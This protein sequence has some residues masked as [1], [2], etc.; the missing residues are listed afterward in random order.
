M[1][2]RQSTDRHEQ[3][4]MAE[5]Q[6]LRCEIEQLRQTTQDLEIALSTIA[7]HGDLV[8]NHLHTA[9]QQLQA[10]IAQRQQA[11]AMLQALIEVLSREKKDLEIIVKTIMEHGDVVDTQWQHKLHEMVLLASMD[12]LTQIPNRRR[13]DEHLEQQWKQ[14]AREKNYL[15]IVLCDIDYF[16]AYNDTLGHLAGDDCLKQVAQALNNTIKRPTDLLARYGGEEFAAVLP[17][18]DEIGALQVA[19]RMQ[20]AIAQQQFRHPAS[21]ISDRITIS[22]G[23]ASAVPLP[24]QSPLTLLDEADRRLYLAKQNGRDQVVATA[25]LPSKSLSS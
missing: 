19:E 1:T 25:T 14:M 9:N 16:K 17:N 20:Q 5:N 18:T 15:S 23:V 2:E 7:E 24:G 8:E 13:F 22:V 10:E 6:R 21:D 12:G 3:A 4:L 11:E